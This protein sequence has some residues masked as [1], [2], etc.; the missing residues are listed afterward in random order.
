MMR[1]YANTRVEDVVER[2][3]VSHGTFYTYYANKSALLTEL[4]ESTAGRLERVAASSWEGD[5]VQGTLERVIGDFLAVYAEEADVLRAWVQAAAVDADFAALLRRLR[6][7]FIQRV[8]DNIE[9]ALPPGPHD[10]HTAASALVAMVEGYTVEHL[11]D[12]AEVP[13]E[14]VVT[15]ATIWRGGLQALA[16]P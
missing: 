3:D 9:P 15:L 8:V 11:P 10:P 14:V 2:A 7:D 4:V 6:A 1:G 16:E 5:D 12:P 13:R